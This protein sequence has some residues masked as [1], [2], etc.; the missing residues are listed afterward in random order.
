MQVAIDG[1][2]LLA[3]VAIASVGLYHVVKWFLNKGQGG[4]K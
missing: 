3:V 1:L 4:P 2:G